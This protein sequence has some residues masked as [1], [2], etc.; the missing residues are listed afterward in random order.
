MKRRRMDTHMA[1]TFSGMLDSQ[2]KVQILLRLGRSG[3]ST[4]WQWRA[5]VA[6]QE[7]AMVCWRQCTALYAAA[8]DPRFGS[9]E[10]A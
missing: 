5:S 1:Q 9:P 8:N 10:V 2:N 6:S 4:N 7:Y 3:F